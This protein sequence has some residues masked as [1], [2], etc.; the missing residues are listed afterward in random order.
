[1]ST[2]LNIELNFDKDSNSITYKINDGEKSPLLD[3]T[4]TFTDELTKI[5]KS[6]TYKSFLDV[7]K[8]YKDK[9]SISG[10]AS[11]F[12]NRYIKSSTV[13]PVVGENSNVNQNNSENDTPVDVDFNRYAANEKAKIRANTFGGKKSKSKRPY[14]ANKTLKNRK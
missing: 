2:S 12:Y 4:S 9:N 1:M 11:S 8:A 7:Y 5:M 10:R 14:N 13:T 6:D 3:G